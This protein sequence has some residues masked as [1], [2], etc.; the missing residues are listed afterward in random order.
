[1]E[2]FTKHT[3]E[4]F[5]CRDITP[6]EEQLLAMA[7]ANIGEYIHQHGTPDY[8]LIDQ[9]DPRN[10]EDYD[11]WCYGTEPLPQDHTW[12][13]TSIDVSPGNGDMAE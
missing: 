2:P 8:V 4:S 11:T 7:L 1:M 12:R 3:N 13:S 5:E 10:E 9:E 6:T